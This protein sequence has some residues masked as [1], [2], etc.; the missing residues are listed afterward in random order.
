M[1]GEVEADV[2]FIEGAADAD[3]GVLHH[4]AGHQ[5]WGLEQQRH[6]GL[7]LGLRVDHLLEKDLGALRQ[8]TL[9]GEVEL[10]AAL[11]LAP[12]TPLDRFV[13]QLRQVDAG[14]LGD[15]L[16]LELGG[17]TDEAHGP[18]RILDAGQ[19]DN[20]LVFALAEHHRL[21]NA[22]LVDAV[23]DDF[24]RLV[25]RIFA[26]IVDFLPAQLQGDARETALL[27]SHP[28]FQVGEG[29]LEDLFDRVDG[30]GVGQ[31]E[32]DSAGR[33][34]IHAD[35]VDVL[36]GQGGLEIRCRQVQ[37]V[38]RRL[39]QVH[40]QDDVH[41]ALQVETEFQAG[42]GHVFLPPVRQPRVE[43]GEQGQGAK[44][45]KQEDEADLEFQTG[46]HG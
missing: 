45:E 41:A 34:R 32:E 21:G 42:R 18:V 20:D 3:L 10:P 43:G 14:G 35:R 16:E 2:G 46:V 8:A 9:Q 23:A 28:G 6:P 22:E 13:D 12:L 37:A 38:F 40:L 4:F 5:H 36:L 25:D 44:D 33:T 24:Q 31:G 27:G 19:L 11:A 29:V 7:A 39:V 30:A 1:A 15:Q 17:L 26:D